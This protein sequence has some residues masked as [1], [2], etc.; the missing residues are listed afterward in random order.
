MKIRNKILIATALMWVG[1]ILITY[2]VSRYYLLDSFLKIEHNAVNHNL[3]R[4]DGAL[5]EVSHSLYTFT[6]DWA[7]WNGS[8]N[9]VLGKNPQFVADNLVMNVYTN[10]TINLLTYWNKSGK[11]IFGTAVDTNSKKLI[12]F[13]ANLNQYLHPGSALLNRTDLDHDMRGYILFGDKIMF[14]AAS[15]I[16]TGEKSKP[17]V[18]AL[19]TGRLLSPEVLNKIASISQTKL[20][21]YT[22]NEIIGN[23]LLTQNL[24]KTIK[25]DGHFYQPLDADNLEGFTLLSDINGK[26]IGYVRMVQPRVV[27]LTGLHA[28]QYYLIMF[29]L[30]G[31]A[32]SILMLAL[33]RTLVIHRLEKLDMQV[34]EIR[35]NHTMNQRVNVDG[36]DELSSVAAEFNAMLDTLQNSQDRLEHHVLERTEELQQANKKLQ[37]EIADRKTVE[38]ELTE[39][40][41]HLVKLAHYDNLTTL[42]NRIFF[43]EIFSKALSHA[44][45]NKKALAVLFID[46]DRFKNINDALGHETGDQV[47]KEIA[48]RLS[49]ILRPGDVLARL[50]GDEFIL[51]LNDIDQ[52]KFASA[53]AE[54]LLH[55]CMKPVVVSGHEFYLTASVGI[56]VFPRDGT[57]LED[58]QRNADMAMYKAKR[59]GGGLFQ[60]FNHSMNME[61]SENIQL[62]AGLRRAIS[63]NEFVLFFQPKL[64]LATGVL[65]GVEA[66]I[67]WNNPSFGLISPA[68]FIPLAEETGLILQMGEWALLEACKTNKRW[69]DQGYSPIS[70]SVNISPKQFRLQDM[71]QLVTSILNTTGLEAKYLELEITETTVME[72]VDDAIKR[73]NDI[74]EMGVSL[75]IDD[76][77]TG[78]SSINYLKKF[79]IDILKIDRTFIK[80]IPDDQND[81]AIT[82]AVIAMAHN[83]G[84]QVVAEGVET[85]EQMKFLAEHG[86]D[87]VQGYFISRPLPEKKIVLQLNRSNNDIPA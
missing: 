71:S 73:L 47:L 51:L 5:N 48:M 12:P 80:G 29:T 63:N 68:K 23:S 17:S 54:E 7:H 61:A 59:S 18:G 25:N 44:T 76:F 70:I 57:S 52:A 82:G 45:R 33:L 28:I 42:P 67:R 21:L 66:L 62:E 79:P 22:N 16:T 13:P 9:F 30:L 84:F 4:V 37:D 8:Y 41:E 26:P 10:S 24:D 20:Q 58:L 75:S 74:Q 1:F 83:L 14:V 56:S 49:G 6:A 36:A 86:C 81:V 35:A 65:I 2:A 15:A 19:V 77:G 64:N 53:V 38:K 72:D 27:Y 78:Y 43:N 39:H 69:Q 55:A 85:A 3:D 11:L 87:I 60:Y 46:I 32:F 40:K 50:G 34:A 31:I